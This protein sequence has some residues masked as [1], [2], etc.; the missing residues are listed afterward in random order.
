MRSLNSW[1]FSSTLPFLRVFCRICNPAALYIRIS[2]PFHSSFPALQMLILRCG[3]IN[4]IRPNGDFSHTEG[5]EEQSFFSPPVRTVRKEIRIIRIITQKWNEFY[6][7]EWMNDK[8]N[9]DARMRADFI[10]PPERGTEVKSFF[11]P[12]RTVRKEIRIS[13]IIRIITRSAAHTPSF[14]IIM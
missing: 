6:K 3:R 10:N 11:S 12:V 13:R 5:T 14:L 8:T 7:R 1:P 9:A 2:F 4:K